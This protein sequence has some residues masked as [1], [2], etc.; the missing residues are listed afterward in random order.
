MNWFPEKFEECELDTVILVAGMPGAGKSIVSEAARTLGLRI[1]RMGD[2]IREIAAENSK[3]PSDEVLGYI[4]QKIRELHGRDIVARAALHIAC[5]EEHGGPVLVEGVRSPEEVE[6]FR[7]HSRRCLTIAVHSPPN[8]RYQRLLARGRKDDPK[9]WEEFKT[10]DERELA[11]GLGSV[12]ALA[13]II[14][15]NHEKRP[16]DLFVEAKSILE[17]VIGVYSSDARG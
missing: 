9:S 13:D 10:R 4:S 7:R 16:E 8:V 2:I 5:S 3:P 15:V 6:Y 14:L 12:I 17:K 11:L 1:V